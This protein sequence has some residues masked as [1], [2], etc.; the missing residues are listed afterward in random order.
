MRASEKGF[1]S[2]CGHTQ[3]VV[4]AFGS[5]MANEIASFVKRPPTWM[6]GVA[7][8]ALLASV[9]TLLVEPWVIHESL[10]EYC[11]ESTT[12][13]DDSQIGR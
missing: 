2:R 6:D 11:T 7:A 1:T 9:G 5:L 4:W 10:A 13:V 8:L 12:K 3:L